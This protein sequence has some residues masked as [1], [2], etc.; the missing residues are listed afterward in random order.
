MIVSG[1]LAF[2]AFSVVAWLTRCFLNPSSVFFVIDLPTDRSLHDRPTPRSGGIAILAG[3]VIAVGAYVILKGLWNQ[4]LILVLIALAIVG[5]IGA[6]DDRRPLSPWIRLAAQLTAAIA[7]MSSGLVVDVIELP[8]LTWVVPPIVVFVMTALGIVWMINVYNFMD[9]MDGLAAGMAVVGFGTFAL[10]GAINGHS[11]FA[12]ANLLVAAAVAGF[13]VFNLPSAKIFMGDVGSYTLGL[14]VAM[15]SIWGVRENIFQLWIALLVFSPFVVDATTTLIRRVLRREPILNA[16]CDHYYQ[17]LV[18][19]GF[20]RRRVLAGECAAMFGATV[21]ALV[22]A[23]APVT[24]QWAVVAVWLVLYTGMAV[25]VTRCDRK[26][27]PVQKNHR[28]I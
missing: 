8:G 10:F 18:R 9:G 19:L 16:H 7:I 27:N 5:G 23:S 15:S 3:I 14:L 28:L 12:T 4:R 20:G 11:S 2:I 24:W 13:L 6:L 26:T 22:A 17:R 25:W 1:S 21:S